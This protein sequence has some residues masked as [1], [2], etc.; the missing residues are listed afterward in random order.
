MDSTVTAV[1]VG[2]TPT[3][4][5]AVI[6]YVNGAKSI[7]PGTN[8]IE[9]AVEAADHK[10]VSKYTITVTCGTASS[11]TTTTD[12]TTDTSSDTTTTG[13]GTDTTE[14]EDGTDGQEPDGDAGSDSDSSTDIGGDLQLIDVTDEVD[15]KAKA[16]VPEVIDMGDGTIVYNSEIYVPQSQASEPTVEAAVSKEKYDNMYDK[17]IKAK[18]RF[19]TTIVVTVV[20]VVILLF[21]ILNLILRLQDKRIEKEVSARKAMTD[22]EIYDEFEKELSEGGKTKQ[23]AEKKTEKGKKVKE[24]PEKEKKYKE[25][26]VKDMTTDD[27]AKDRMSRKKKASDDD[28]DVQVIDLNNL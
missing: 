2:A 25:K 18:N 19:T 4:S 8:T 28:E 5:G 1:S 12:T 15:E 9:V 17:Y 27:M 11:T 21:V 10:S 22:D 26:S 23:P 20:I 6:A 24:K 14:P 3:D 16:E 13:T 7:K